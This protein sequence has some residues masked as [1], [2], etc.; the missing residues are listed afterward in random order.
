MRERPGVCERRKSFSEASIYRQ[1]GGMGR[2]MAGG[3]GSAWLKFDALP[4][5]CASVE[6]TRA[7][8]EGGG[9]VRMS[10]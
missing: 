2:G 5:H 8:G 9:A 6:V 1:R 10:G 3:M 4:G 7:R